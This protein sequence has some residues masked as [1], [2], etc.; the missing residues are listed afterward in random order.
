M[1][2]DCIVRP[3]KQW[4]FLQPLNT[5]FMVMVIEGMD[6][7]HIVCTA[8]IHSML[9]ADKALQFLARQANWERQA[10]MT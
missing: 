8:G 9:F 1:L 7:Q 10:H 3:T 4:Y 5:E 2:S 6:G